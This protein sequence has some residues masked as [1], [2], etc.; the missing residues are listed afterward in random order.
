MTTDPADRAQAIAIMKQQLTDGGMEDQDAAE[1]A[2]HLVD[3]AIAQR[4]G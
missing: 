2:E 3:Q 4:G 1:V